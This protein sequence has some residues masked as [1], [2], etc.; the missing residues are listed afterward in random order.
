MK[1]A[2]FSAQGEHSFSN[3]QLLRLKA[4]KPSF[5]T[6]TRQLGKEEFCHLAREFPILA[7]TRRSLAQLD[8]DV[9][10]HLP[11]LRG[12]AVF[13]T[14]VEW[15]DV[16]HLKAL[17]IL[18]R[19]LIDYCSTSVAEHALGM[20]LTFSR[21]LH[22]SDAKARGQVGANVSLRGFE[23]EGKTLGILGLGKIGNKLA[24][25]ASALG[26]PIS[27]FDPKFKVGGYPALTFEKVLRLSDF[28]AVCCPDQGHILIGDQEI[29]LMKPGSY[30]INTSRASLVDTDAVVDAIRS[31][32]LAGYGVDEIVLPNPNLEP[33]RLLQTHHTAW[34]SN[35]ALE[36]GTEMWVGNIITLQQQLSRQASHR[37]GETLRVL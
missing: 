36:R 33:G 6:A 8:K 13:S 4:V 37:P 23:L 28:V 15:L 31:K 30:L 27:F 18:F 32:H 3:E 25:K 29:A 7:L 10:N 22:L 24:R 1:A 11:K 12:V 35:E 21:R 26:M 9:L 14:G 2:I 19:P 5:F 16:A 34:Y 17:G 20:I